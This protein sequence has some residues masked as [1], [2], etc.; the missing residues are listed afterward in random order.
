MLAHFFENK[1]LILLEKTDTAC[2]A[3]VRRTRGQ[4]RKPLLTANFPR[5]LLDTKFY[6]A[7]Y[8]QHTMLNGGW[9]DED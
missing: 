6:I 9:C 3:P 8:V 2:L 7:Y 1:K 4:F 5:Y